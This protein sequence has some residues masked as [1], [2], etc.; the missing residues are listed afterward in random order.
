MRVSCE[1]ARRRYH[2]WLKLISNILYG[3]TGE[4]MGVGGGC[5]PGSR[6]VAVLV[7]VQRSLGNFRWLMDQESSRFYPISDIWESRTHRKS[8]ANRF[9][10]S[11]ARKMSIGSLYFTT[12]HRMPNACPFLI[13]LL[14]KCCIFDRSIGHEFSHSRFINLHPRRMCFMQSPVL[15]QF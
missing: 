14:T 4:W 5:A 10:N 9:W 15:G 7:L 1:Y 8:L 6:V 12:D 3:I 2:H 11:G 13:A